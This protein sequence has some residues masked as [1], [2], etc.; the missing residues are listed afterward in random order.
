[1]TLPCHIC[2]IYFPYAASSSFPSS[3]PPSFS[4]FFSL[5]PLLFP[6]F[7]P[8][9]TPPLFLHLYIRKGL[10]YP[11]Q[12]SSLWW[13]QAGLEHLILLRCWSYRQAL[14]RSAWYCP[15]K[16]NLSI[17]RPESV[18]RINVH[19]HSEDCAVSH[20]ICLRHFCLCAFISFLSTSNEHAC[21][22]K[23]LVPWVSLH[24]QRHLRESGK[25][26][27][28]WFN[29]LLTDSRMYY[30]YGSRQNN[31]HDFVIEKTTSYSNNA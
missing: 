7:P 9:Y 28:I 4:H 18:F 31:T 14:P 30:F 2:L 5:S 20:F 11:R 27:L 23:H 25:H 12:V 15:L 16:Y 19:Y 1:M 10:M 13:S 26:F 29:E 3:L 21:V 22:A 6:S 24:C 17:W 8:L